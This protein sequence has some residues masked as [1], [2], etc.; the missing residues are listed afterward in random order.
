MGIEIEI[1]CPFRQRLPTGLSRAWEYECPM[2][3]QA[4]ACACNTIY[5]TIKVPHRYAVQGSDTTMMPNA[6]LFGQ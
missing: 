3:A 4:A 6:P 2:Q 1:A 5:N